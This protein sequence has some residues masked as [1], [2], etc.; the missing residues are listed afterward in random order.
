MRPELSPLDWAVIALYLVFAIGL[1]LYFTR[2]ASSSIQSFF[3]GDRQLPWWLAGTSIV[4]TTFAADTPLA[5]TGLVASGGISANWIWWCVAIGHVFSTF[6]FAHLWRRS[7]VITDAEITELRYSGR[8]AAALRAFKAVYFGIFINCLTMAW[9]IAAMVKISQAFFSIEPVWVITLCIFF[10]VLYTTLG[11]FRS[12]VFTDL[13]QFVLG[14]GGSLVLAY[15]T[16]GHFGGLGSLPSLQY[17]QG[18]GLL[19]ALAELSQRG[20][21]DV[22]EVLDFIPNAEHPTTPIF[23]F[24]ALIFAGWWRYAEGNGYIVQRLAACRDEAQAQGASLWFSIAHNALRPWPWILVGLAA[25][26]IYPKLPQQAPAS[27]SIANPHISVTPATLDVHSGGTLNFQ[28]IQGPGFATL[29][30]QRVPLK[31]VEDGW[32]AT[33]G[34][35]QKSQIATLSIDLGATEHKVPGMRIELLD[36]EQGY[37]ILMGLFLPSGLLG[38]V[39]ASLL[40][41][42]MSTIDTHTNWGASYL[43]RD[44]Y[45]RFWRPNESE[46]HYVWVSRACILLIAVLAGISASFIQNIAEVWKFLITLGAGLG[47]V[48]AVRWYWS[49]VTA[50]AEFAALGITTFTALTL[51]LF[52]TPKIF[53]GPN[54]WLLVSVPG[55]AQIIGVALLS[56]ATWIPVALFGPQTDAATLKHFAATIAPGGPGWKGYTCMP[57]AP[58]KKLLWRFSAG[59]AAV[60]G[61]LFGLGEILLGSLSL[62]ALMLVLTAALLAWVIYAPK[63]KSSKPQKQIS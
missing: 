16:L 11:G 54:P 18:T 3:V 22:N 45:Q 37:P 19:G 42:F 52:F 59:L 31:P 39:I 35:F 27:L 61:C 36:R 57:Q 34:A 62:G 40:A 17:D 53:G 55:W 47:S 63:D 23:L 30:T 29:Q 20:A 12:V 33:F 5:V 58:F 7:N 21:N 28:G 15:F 8:A 60:Y 2:R 41:A 24:L 10:S 26:V 51:Q 32:V 9:V 46:T 25:L 13:A 49:K 6:F 38:L 56:L 50:Y 43:V 4:A 48:T 14:I 1:G 44:L